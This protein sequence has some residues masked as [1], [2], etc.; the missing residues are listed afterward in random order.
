MKTKILTYALLIS[1]LITLGQVEK[2]SKDRS[3]FGVRGGLNYSNIIYGGS[4]DFQPKV[5]F[6]LGGTYNLVSGKK[7]TLPMEL[8][9]SKIGSKTDYAD[10]DFSILNVNF[11]INYYTS[12]NFFLEGGMI[13]GYYLTAEEKDSFTNSTRNISD[14]LM[15]VDISLGVGLGYEFTNR[16]F[17]NLRYA[18]GILPLLSE[19]DKNSHVSNF[20]LNFGYTF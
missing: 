6:S 11:M 3:R 7:L 13:T 16:T 12:K 2:N 19:D 17:L 8:L 4:I 9:Y 5:G 15:G 14:Q 1:S 18:Y 20:S 10:Y